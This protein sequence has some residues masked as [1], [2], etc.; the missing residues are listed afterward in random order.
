MALNRNVMMPDGAVR[1]WHVVDNILHIAGQET[2]YEVISTVS[3]TETEDP[4]RTSIVLDLDDS[5]T[6]AGAYANLESDERFAE[7]T[8]PAQ[9]ALDEVL[10]ILTDD[11]AVTVPD[12]FPSWKPDTE[13]KV[14]DRRNHEGVLY[15]CLQ[16]HTSQEDYSPD[17]AVSLWAR[18]LNPD[19]EVIPVWVQ[20]DSTNSYMKGDKVHYPTADDPIYISIQDYNVFAPDVAGWELWEGGE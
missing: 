16:A 2:R 6:F 8:D 13:Y 14:G 10:P 15:K 11:Q 1:G 17:K 9:A 18:M 5:L 20:P 4:Y 3:E 12:A 7:Y 19:P